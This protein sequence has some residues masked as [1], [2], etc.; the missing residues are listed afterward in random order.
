MRGFCEGLW[1][2]LLVDELWKLLNVQTQMCCEFLKDSSPSA[3][4]IYDKVSQS[5]LLETILQ[6][7]SQARHPQTQET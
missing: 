1:I 3:S 4:V 7:E 6:D 2:F 5:P